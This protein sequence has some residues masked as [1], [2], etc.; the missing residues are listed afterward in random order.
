M[1]KILLSVV[2]IASLSYADEFDLVS[3]TDQIKTLFPMTVQEY[4]EFV[5]LIPRMLSKQEKMDLALKKEQERIARLRA[6]KAKAEKERL[7][8]EKI[9]KN[10]KK[11]ADLKDVNKKDLKVK[12]EDKNVDFFDSLDSTDDKP[13]SME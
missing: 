6:K 4:R 7:K 2:A 3:E 12:I 10:F 9:S 8:K 1:R 13:V 5:P 11:K